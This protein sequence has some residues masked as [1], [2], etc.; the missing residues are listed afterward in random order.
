MIDTA[1]ITI[2]H[3]NSVICGLVTRLP[4]V[5][6]VVTSAAV[7]RSRDDDAYIPTRIYILFYI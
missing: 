2:E 3:N 6:K 7:P 4:N 1:N 5:C